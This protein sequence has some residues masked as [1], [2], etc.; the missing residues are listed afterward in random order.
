MNTYNLSLRIG[1]LTVS[2]LARH[3]LTEA[4]Q[5]LE[6]FLARHQRCDWGEVDTTGKTFNDDAAANGLDVTSYYR[7]ATG[8][9]LTITTE[10]D[11]EY[12]RVDLLPLTG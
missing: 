2:D 7:L 12:S 8:V 3:A 11:R 5:D 1:Q 9:I 10:F 4:D 6:R